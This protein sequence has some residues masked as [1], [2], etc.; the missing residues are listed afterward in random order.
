MLVMRNV[1]SYVGNGVT[2]ELR[3]FARFKICE[4]SNAFA[5]QKR[6]MPPEDVFLFR[7]SDEVRET[8]RGT[9]S[10]DGTR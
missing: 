9:Q 4:K 1:M 10:S 2:G 3:S 5:D 8:A 7:V 6:V